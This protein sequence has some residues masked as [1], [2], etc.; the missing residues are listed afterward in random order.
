MVE[1]IDVIAEP[2]YSLVG[3]SLVISDASEQLN[4]VGNYWC[5]ASNEFGG[6]LSSRAKLE[7]GCKY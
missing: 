2:R 7:F 3:G 6:I 4:D 5:E 1:P